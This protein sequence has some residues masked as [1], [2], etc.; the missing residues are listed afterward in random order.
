MVFSVSK[1]V[2]ISRLYK[3]EYVI[4]I[5]PCFMLLIYNMSVIYVRILIL[6]ELITNDIES[7]YAI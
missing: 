4:F 6:A 1:I 3:F 5:I 7:L 2:S